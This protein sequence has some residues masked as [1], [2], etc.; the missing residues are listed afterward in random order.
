MNI[1]SHFQQRQAQYQVCSTV[2]YV[3]NTRQVANCKANT[4][5]N[6]VQGLWFGLILKL[7]HS[8]LH[9]AGSYS[10]LR[11]ICLRYPIQ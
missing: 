11:L 1:Q 10:V 3:T 8:L 4:L 9:S 6:V 2:F 5:Q 7:E